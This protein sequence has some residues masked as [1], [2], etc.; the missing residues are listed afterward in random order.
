MFAE[1]FIAGGMVK[2]RFKEPLGIGLTI[3]CLR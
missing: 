2:K 3:R 1:D